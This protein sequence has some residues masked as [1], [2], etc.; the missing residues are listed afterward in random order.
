MLLDKIR[1]LN[2]QFFK[3][4]GKLHENKANL[5]DM[6]REGVA[7]NLYD[8]Y[9]LD[10]KSIRYML[11]EEESK[12]NEL[13]R[14]H[15]EFLFRCKK[16]LEELKTARENELEEIKQERERLQAEFEN[17]RQQLLNESK[18]ARITAERE[19]KAEL[20][21]RLAEIELEKEKR[22]NEIA[23]ARIKQNDEADIMLQSVNYGYIVK[24]SII[25]PRRKA[26][27]TIGKHKF[28]GYY[29]N[30]A[31]DL[32]QA[33]AEIEAQKYL[34]EQA[35]KIA[36]QQEIYN[37]TY[38]TKYEL[39]EPTREPKWAKKRRARDI[40]ADFEKYANETQAEEQ[41]APQAPE[42]EDENVIPQA[43][44]DKPAEP[45]NAPAEAQNKPDGSK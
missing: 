5:N 43:G 22:M 4:C 31:W 17:E 39:P 32:A 8:L 12:I 7:K 16:E 40:S 33:A 30:R 24:R 13:E 10:Y 15:E 27:H 25:T 14:A 18:A 19:A 20:E 1:E 28:G 3:D 6:Q 21:A 38:G 26:R 37:D 2:E 44:E 11:T 29:T 42:I 23:L 45:Q 36:E 41:E 34:A 9:M 35:D